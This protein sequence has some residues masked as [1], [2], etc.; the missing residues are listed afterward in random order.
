[1]PS[2]L[3]HRSPV[4]IDHHSSLASL[5]SLTFLIFLYPY[6]LILLHPSLHILM[7]HPHAHSHRLSSSGFRSFLPHFFALVASS[8]YCSRIG[9]PPLS[10]GHLCN[11]PLACFASLTFFCIAVYS[12]PASFL[13]LRPAPCF[14]CCVHVARSIHMHL[15]V[16]LDICWN[17]FVRTGMDKDVIT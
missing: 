5:T 6:P 2:A 7:S 15:S 12:I 8:F 14:C 17:S 11:T 1:V 16:R 13:L 10:R 3:P 4:R 9:E